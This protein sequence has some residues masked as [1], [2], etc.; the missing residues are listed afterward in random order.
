MESIFQYC[1]KGLDVEVLQKLGTK[2]KVI[3]DKDFLFFYQ[4]LLPLC[5][6]DSLGVD[7]NPR[8]SYYSKVESFTNVYAVQFG[9][10]GTYGHKFNNV[11]VEELLHHNGCIVYDGV[12][13]GS[14]G[15]IYWQWIPGSDYD[16]HM[17]QSQTH[18]R[19]LQIKRVKKFCFNDLAAKKDED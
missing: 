14:G 10:G 1:R 19:W 17:Y 3:T 8:M 11:D 13:G 5:N 7:G 4:L 2:E 9:L 16:D 12:R 15:A 6:V 18:R